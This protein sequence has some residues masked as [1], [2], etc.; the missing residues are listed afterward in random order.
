MLRKRH[1]R[2]L[3]LLLALVLGLLI[4]SWGRIWDIEIQGNETIS[5]GEILQ[6][7]SECGIDI[8]ESW[9]SYSQDSVRNSMILKIP[10][11]RWMTVSMQGCRA[12]VRV[13]ERRSY[14]EP[15][16]EGE[17]ASIVSDKAGIVTEV[18]ALRGTAVTESGK[19]VLPGETL[20]A[21]YATGRFGVQGPVRAIGSVK[22]QTWYDLTMAAP[23]ELTI[24]CPTGEE[25]TLF[26]LIL[27]KMRIN[28]YKGSSICPGNCDKIIDRYTVAQTGWFALPLTLEKT[29]LSAYTTQTQQAAELQEELSQALMAELTERIGEDGQ[30]ESFTFTAS[31]E[32][33][34]LYVTLHAQ[35][36]ETIGTTVPLTEADLA[37]IQ[38]KISQTEETDP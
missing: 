5:D 31:E 16:P 6:A 1:C 24:K 21:G 35:C 23:L 11:I 37:D 36:R 25:K 18:N 38:L 27:G 20:I 14:I 8:G 34:L 33:G 12:I 2:G 29:T 15:V 9:L 28:F 32:D 22:A 4:A 13:R 30:V 10:E 26:S 17:Y 7:L 19:A 3:L